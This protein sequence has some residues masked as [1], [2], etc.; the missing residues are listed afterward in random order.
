VS[1]RVRACPKCLERSGLVCEICYGNGYVTEPRLED[2]RAILRDE[3]KGGKGLGPRSM[4]SDPPDRLGQTQRRAYYVWLAIS[5]AEKIITITK[6]M[7]NNAERAV[8][9]D[10]WL[11]EIQQI[12]KECRRIF[13]P[14]I[15]E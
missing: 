7:L 4:R 5:H 3:A 14:K 12:A 9:G 8:E 11:P 6:G 2:I 10:P 13:F 1:Q 15:S